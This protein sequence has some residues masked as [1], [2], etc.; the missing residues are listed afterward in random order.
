MEEL[1]KLQKN[2]DI[3]EDQQK[4]GEQ[5]IQKLTDSSIADVAKIAEAKEKE[6]MEI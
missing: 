5:K 4:E 6:I 2:G 3:S 1:K